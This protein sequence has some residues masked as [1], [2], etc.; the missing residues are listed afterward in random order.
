M[1]LPE[2]LITLFD[3]VDT[4]EQLAFEDEHLNVVWVFLASD[5]ELS[6][7]KVLIRSSN[8]GEGFQVDELDIF[9]FDCG[10]QVERIVTVTLF[11]KSQS[12]HEI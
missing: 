3:L 2:H 5:F 6:K 4:P 12:L 11:D 1:G 7:S 8:V 9:S 10:Y